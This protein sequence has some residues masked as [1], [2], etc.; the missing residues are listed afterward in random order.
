MSRAIVLA[1]LIAGCSMQ[2]TVYQRDDGTPGSE[3]RFQRDYARCR[4]Q[5]AGLAQRQG[6]N[7]QYGPYDAGGAMRNAGADLAAVG[8]QLQFVEDC[9]RAEG[10]VR[11]R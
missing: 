4:A 11:A 2:P 7:Y 8:N 1:L 5:S 9:L 6:P 10:W 3:N